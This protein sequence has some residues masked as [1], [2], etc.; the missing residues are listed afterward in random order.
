M[1]TDNPE[2][3]EASIE[4]RLLA[5]LTPEAATE[6]E[7]VEQTPVADDS[8]EEVET[9]DEET[10][11]EAEFSEVQDEEGRTHKVPAALKDQ[12]LMR[13]D[14]TRKTM[15]AANLA[16]AAQDRMQ[17]AE[18]REQIT[19][20]VVQD[21][22]E[23]KALELQLKQYEGMDMG[24]LYQTDPGTALRLRDQRDELRRQIAEKQQA[25]GTKARTLQE[26]QQQHFSKQWQMAIE[27]AKQRIGQYTPG[28][29]AA[30]LKQVQSLG[31]TEEEMRG[32]YADP[33][34]L[35]AIYKAAKWDTLQ[36]NKGKAVKSAES[37]P[38]VV[39]PGA[40]KG[41]GVAADQ[42]YRQTRES[43]KKSGSVHDAA[44]LFMLRG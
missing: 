15:E 22:A 17:F 42:K 27:G 11:E 33:R 36:A 44:K 12:F 38:P 39:K 16:K 20:A 25:I 30:M 32:R 31:F 43:L 26:G 8:A 24:A 13:A 21:I 9:D 4:D 2:G 34:I 40:S 41:P 10:P 18:A 6:A 14:Y 35:H 1:D 5:S 19:A 7:E 3:P 23:V 37:A 28:E 29:D